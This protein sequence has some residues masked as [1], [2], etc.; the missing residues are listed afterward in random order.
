MPFCRVSCRYDKWIWPR[1]FHSSQSTSYNCKDT[2]LTCGRYSFSLL[3]RTAQYNR[4]LL[5]YPTDVYLFGETK[6]DKYL[7]RNEATITLYDD[8]VFDLDCEAEEDTQ[9]STV[10]DEREKDLMTMLTQFDRT[11]RECKPPS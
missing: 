3:K 2:F 10:T 5:S 7:S 11:P 8:A 4:E 1:T 9:Q 6:I